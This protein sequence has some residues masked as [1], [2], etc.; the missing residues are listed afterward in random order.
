MSSSN[1]NRL[2]AVGGFF[3]AGLLTF[4]FLAAITWFLAGSKTYRE[5]KFNAHQ[6]FVTQVNAGGDV[7]GDQAIVIV[8][9]G[10]LKEMAA[11][12]GRIVDG[13]DE[14]TLAVMARPSGGARGFVADIENRKLTKYKYDKGQALAK[15]A[16][17]IGANISARGVKV[18]IVPEG[19]E[20]KDSA[21]R[22]TVFTGLQAGG[23]VPAFTSTTSAKKTLAGTGKRPQQFA[24]VTDAPTFAAVT[25]IDNWKFVVTGDD[26]DPLAVVKRGA[27]AATVPEDDMKDLVSSAASAADESPEQAS[28]LQ[29]AAD[30]VSD[31]ASNLPLPG[32]VPDA[33]PKPKPKPKPKPA[34]AP[35]QPGTGSGTGSGSN[36]AG[37][38]GGSGGGNGGGGGGNGGGGGGGGNGGGGN[39]TGGA[40]GGS[41]G[42]GGGGGGGG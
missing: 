13:G 38:N 28:Q 7:D 42:A 26:A 21:W 35:V 9:G 36:G 11:G 32:E 40:G 18:V 6:V 34:P 5:A 23:V 37:G 15:A 20:V 14:E 3:G 4:L 30:L 1:N 2:K 41:D 25:E 24:I 29:S 8:N 19:V 39:G 33:E 31:W 22:R 10:S 17:A 27:L 12:K 16:Q